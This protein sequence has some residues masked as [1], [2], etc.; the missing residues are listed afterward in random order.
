MWSRCDQML[1]SVLKS[2]KTLILLCS[3]PPPYALQPLHLE[4][5]LWHCL[6]PWF[7]SIVRLFVGKNLL[8]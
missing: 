3:V 4:T 7:F 5:L 8:G 2:S 6:L 1:L